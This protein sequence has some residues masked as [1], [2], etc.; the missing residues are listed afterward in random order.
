MTPRE[1]LIQEVLQMPDFLVEPLLSLLRSLHLLSDDKTTPSATRLDQL[2]ADDPTLSD[3]QFS[4]QQEGDDVT[5]ASSHV[6]P[7]HT[8]AAMQHL[9]NS[10][11]TFAEDWESP[12]MSIY[13]DY[14]T[15]KEKL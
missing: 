9:R 11:A 5:P 15:A 10:L 14:D 3:S 8:Q 1:Q 6:L 2:T 13:D 7:F 4:P 12:E